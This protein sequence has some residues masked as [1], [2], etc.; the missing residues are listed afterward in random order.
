MSPE[1]LRQIRNVLFRTLAVTFALSLL[2]QLA[3]FSL[4]DTWTGLTSQWF[5]TDVEQLGP[6]VL[7]FFAGVK[8]YAIF[9]LL[10]PALALHWTV[11]AQ[12]RKGASS[13]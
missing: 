13:A 4:W 12:E 5:H 6:V 1:L 7:R 9:I 11:K 10:A 8:F 3:T 2:M